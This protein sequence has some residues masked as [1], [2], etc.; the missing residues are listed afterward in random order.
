VS[1]LEDLL[2][3]FKVPVFDKRAKRLLSSHPKFYYFDVG[4]FNALRP[5]GPLDHFPNIAGIA[6]ETLVAQHLKAWIDYS[7]TP[8]DL[9]FWRTKSGLE[10]DF[11]IYGESSFYAIEVKSSTSIKPSDLRGLQAF[12]EDYPEAKPI[13][14][15]RGKE[16]LMQKGIL[17]YPLDAFLKALVPSRGIAV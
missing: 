15:Y 2:L 14:V 10:V 7:I 12:M 6:L 5:K 4:V 3:S 9:Y 11:V 8:A 17:C 13:L 16:K 1:I